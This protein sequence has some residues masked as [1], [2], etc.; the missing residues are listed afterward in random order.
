MLDV[1]GFDKDVRGHQRTW[2]MWVDE[3]VEYQW[4]TGSC[5]VRWC[6]LNPD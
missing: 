3:L 2:D 5:E 1:V 6:R 4:A